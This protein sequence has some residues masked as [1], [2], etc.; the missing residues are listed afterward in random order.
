MNL[1]A[2]PEVVTKP[3]TIPTRVSARLSDLGHRAQRLQIQ[4]E[5]FYLSAI[6]VT[7]VIFGSLVEDAES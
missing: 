7:T 5:G 2:S 1:V 4:I 3:P 6:H